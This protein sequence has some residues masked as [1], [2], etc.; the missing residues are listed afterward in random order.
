MGEMNPVLVVDDDESYRELLVLTLEDQCGVTQVQGFAG[1]RPLLH[2]LAG[3]GEPP[4]LVLLDLHMP[5]MSGLDLMA[6]VRSIAPRVPVAFLSGAAGPEER[7]ACIAAG[8]AAF[9]RKPAAYDDLIQVLQDLVRD[10]V[11]RAR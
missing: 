7:A 9:V 10:H 3:E 1:A 11:P 8:A 5:D 6:Q 2:H 4:A